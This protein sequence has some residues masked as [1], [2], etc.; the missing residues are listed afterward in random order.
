MDL[1]YRV[2]RVLSVIGP[3]LEGIWNGHAR[4]ALAGR[5]MDRSGKE[6]PWYTVPAVDALK[7]WDFSTK[8]VLEFGGGSSTVWWAQNARA[9]T[10]VESHPAWC[11]R[12]RQRLAAD[13]TDGKVTLIVA[14]APPKSEFANHQEKFDVIVVDDGTGKGPYGRVDNYFIA[15]DLLADDGLIIIDNSDAP[16]MREAM[17][18]DAVKSNLTIDLWGLAAGSMRRSCTS[19]VFMG[20]KPF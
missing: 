7:R 1:G 14:K 8:S 2:K 4:S 13:G 9:V 12:I 20:R 11:E 17:E 19:F 3:A 15:L 5:A 10:C 18:H 16:Y 6:I